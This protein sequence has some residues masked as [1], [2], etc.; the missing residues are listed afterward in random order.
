[1][2]QT[3]PLSTKGQAIVLLL[4][5]YSTSLAASAAPHLSIQ[6]A[7]REVLFH[8]TIGT[9]NWNRRRKLYSV[10]DFLLRLRGGQDVADERCFVSALVARPAMAPPQLR[11]AAGAGAGKWRRWWQR[12]RRRRGSGGRPEEQRQVVRRS[13]E[14]RSREET[15]AYIP[16]IQFRCHISCFKV[17]D[18]VSMRV[19]VQSSNSFFLCKRSL[20]N[21]FS[22]F[23]Y[24]GFAGPID[25]FQVGDAAAGRPHHDAE[26]VAPGQVAHLWL[27]PGWCVVRSTKWVLLWEARTV[28]P[29]GPSGNPPGR[30]LIAFLICSPASLGLLSFA[31]RP[32][33]CNQ[34]LLCFA[35][36][37]Q[38][39]PI[40]TAMLHYSPPPLPR[41]PL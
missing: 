4:T 18:M 1:M 7:R 41:R 40:A 27:A 36:S 35:L 20:P 2:L 11:P 19:G 6:F 21:A 39:R 34:P 5:S 30:A 10:I 12:R 22:S 28:W 15:A 14:G 25:Q 37:L 3:L 23:C 16:H 33:L 13:M 31:A 32:P 29:C 8:V 9:G 17:T 26:P 38:P 24:G